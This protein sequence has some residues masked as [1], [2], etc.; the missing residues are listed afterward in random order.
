ML[1]TRR[2]E[3]RKAKGEEGRDLRGQCDLKEVEKSYPIG[4]D[5]VLTVPGDSKNF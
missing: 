2:E 5:R 3:I 1:L 4:P